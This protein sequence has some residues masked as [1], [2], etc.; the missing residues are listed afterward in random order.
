MRI[1]EANPTLARTQVEKAVNDP[2]GLITTNADNMMLDLYGRPFHEVTICFSWNDTRMSASM[3]SILEDMMIQ[4]LES[5]GILWLML[6][7]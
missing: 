2:G 3:E 1:V 7:L 4:E 6:A 5:I